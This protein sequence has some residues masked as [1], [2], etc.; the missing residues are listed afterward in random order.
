MISRIFTFSLLVIL[1]PF[2][3]YTQVSIEGHVYGEEKEPLAGANVYF[4]ELETGT[5][6]NES[7][8]FRIGGLPAGKFTMR[9]SFVG[10]ETVIQTLDTRD[11]SRYL[12]INLD[13]SIFHSQEVVISG[14]RPSSQH[15]NAIRIETVKV[16][17][18]S[19]EATPSI[20]KALT[21]VPNVNVISKGEGIVTP[22]IRG[23]SSSNILVLYNGIRME[24]YQ[25]S[26]NHP[27]LVDESGIGKV[28]II[29]GPAS[30]LYGSDAI[31]GVLNFIPEKNAP[32]GSIQGSAGIR[33]Q[34]NTNGVSANF[35]IKGAQNHWVWG[36]RGSVSSFMDYLQGNRKY[37][38]NSRFNKAFLRMFT[39]YSNSRGV[40]RISYQYVKMKAGMTVPPAIAE[41][42]RRGRWNDLWYQD[43]DYHLLS[44][45][46]TLFFE[47]MKLGVN[48]AYQDNHRRLFGSPGE[49]FKKVDARLRSVNYEAKA[50]ITSGRISN[51]IITV[52]GMFQNNKNGEA[53]DHVLPDY[54]LND[55]SITGLIQHDFTDRI[56]LQA[57]VRFDNRF[58]NIPIQLRHGHDHEEENGDDGKNEDEAEYME[59][60]YRYYG[61]FSGSLGITCDITWNLL[62]RANVASAYRSPN[63]AE[64][65]Q[66]GEHGVRYEQG[67]IN[68]VSQRN[69]EADLGIHFHTERILVD[70]AGFYNYIDNYIF[71]APTS[72][73]TGEGNL[74]YRYTQGGATLYGFEA[75]VEVLTTR[76]LKLQGDY[77]YVRGEQT[78]GSNLPFIPQSKFNLGVK[79]FTKKLGP[80]RDPYFT[81]NFLLAFS[82]DF[83]AP[84]ET[85]SNS[86]NLLNLGIGFEIP[87]QR[88]RISVE[89]AV[90]NLLDTEYIDHLSTLKDLGYYDA[91]RNIM[92]NVRIP[93]EIK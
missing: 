65:T 7:G 28:E 76:W 6:T 86:Y 59:P 23:L 47:G 16:T 90:S 55:I 51:F 20:M 19:R 18:L 72:D 58:I 75:T 9:T 84:F 67:D 73:T 24:N 83:P 53:P 64:L 81:A 25:F 35:G 80:F 13:P 66:D 77:G 45:R 41:I 11:S 1:I 5:S 70:V 85:K 71:L 63:I 91:G 17:K 8:Y 79:V 30:L 93:F 27:Y 22:V 33:Y 52:Q 57:G 62:L 69:Y 37:V 15:E 88:Q 43:L 44:S 56:H 87:V 60:L 3:V 26:V 92:V 38:P 50:T 2:H 36:I 31:G 12:H 29:K 82:Q 42:D 49:D 48:L 74:I 78:N 4:P 10:Y 68:L 54:I 32:E 61:N 89:L 14:G 21:A 34:S 46:N 39:G 40:Y